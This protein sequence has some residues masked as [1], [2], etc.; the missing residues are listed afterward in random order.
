MISGV[1]GP[2]TVADSFGMGENNCGHRRTAITV[3]QQ[4]G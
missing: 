3:K 1:S 2:L 4:A